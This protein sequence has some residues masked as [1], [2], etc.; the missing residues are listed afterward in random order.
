MEQVGNKALKP[1]FRAFEKRF[2]IDST[3]PPA[4]PRYAQIVSPDS[5]ASSAKE[6]PRQRKPRQKTKTSKHFYSRKEGR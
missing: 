1:Y 4:I 3:T 2:G 6:Q 5:V